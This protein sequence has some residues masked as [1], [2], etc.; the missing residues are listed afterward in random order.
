MRDEKVLAGLSGLGPLGGVSAV[1]SR[2]LEIPT[3]GSVKWA[4]PFLGPH[5]IMSSPGTRLHELPHDALIAILLQL[6]ARE[7]GSLARTCKAL[8]QLVQVRQHA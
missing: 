7:W 2:P 5:T 3:P 4:R 1:T 8:N 6:S